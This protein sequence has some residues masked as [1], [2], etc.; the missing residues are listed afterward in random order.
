MNIKIHIEKLP[1]SHRLE[2][3]Y[4]DNLLDIFLEESLDDRSKVEVVIHEIIEALFPT[5]EHEK[6]DVV[7][8]YIME[9]LDQLNIWGDR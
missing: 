8:D 4:S 7:T 6:V 1:Q 5:I 3:G 2:G 9:G